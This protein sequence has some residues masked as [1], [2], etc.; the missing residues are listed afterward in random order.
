MYVEGVS[1]IFCSCS[2]FYF[3]ATM[4]NITSALNWVKASNGLPNSQNDVLIRLVDAI[5]LGK[6]DRK[7]NKFILRNGTRIDPR[8]LNLSWAEII[9]P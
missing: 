7:E 9:A 1:L 6:Y 4:Y 8:S 3:Y 5:S 2:K